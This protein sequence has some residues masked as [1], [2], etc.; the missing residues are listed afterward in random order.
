MFANVLSERDESDVYVRRISGLMTSIKSEQTS[1]TDHLED[2]KVSRTLL[3]YLPSVRSSADYFHSPAGFPARF[4]NLYG[5]RYTRMHRPTFCSYH[6]FVVLGNL[7]ITWQMGGSLLLNWHCS[8]LSMSDVKLPNSP[9]LSC[10]AL[11]IESK[12]NLI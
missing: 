3:S 4:I 7:P 8:L 9:L 10:A 2:I 5:E 12:S 11:F 6:H 1:M